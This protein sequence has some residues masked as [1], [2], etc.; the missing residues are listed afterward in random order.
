VA[1][2]I[3]ACLARLPTPD[4]IHILVTTRGLPYRV[5]LDAGYVVGFE[6]LL[7][8]HRA[9]ANADASALAGSPQTDQGG[10]FSASV[11]NPSHVGALPSTDRCDFTESNDYAQWYSAAC[12]LLR[13]G[14]YPAPFDRH[15]D[16]DHRVWALS[17]NLFI[18]TRL[19]GFDANDAM[20]LV[21]RAIAADGTFPSSP[22]LCMRG[23]DSARGARDPECEMVVR[24]LAA[25]GLPAAWVDTFD[26]DLSGEV[27]SGYLTG[28]ASM[29]G[30]IAG[31][32]YEPGAVVDNLT[33]YGA[34]PQNFFCDASG[35]QCP[36]SESQTSVARFIRA[37]ATGA[38]GT[39][40]E[41]LNNV[42]PNASLYLLYSAGYS[43]GE[44]YLFSQRYL[45]WQNLTLGDPLTTPHAMRP[46]VLDGETTVAEG[47]TWI[48]T[49]EHA[50]GITWTRAYVDDQL[51]AEASGPELPVPVDLLGIEGDTV[52]VYVVA[53]AAA[54]SLDRT[55]WPVDPITPTPGVRGWR[56]LSVSIGP[57]E[58][59]PDEDTGVFEEHDT[60][61]PT[62]PR[63]DTSPADSGSPGS[64]DAARPKSESGGC[65]TLSHHGRGLSG[66]VL[67]LALGWRRRR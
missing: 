24:Y 6:A 35:E 43:L 42:F 65:T 12:Q 54:T 29:T 28:A 15:A 11:I 52:D 59:S 5:D 62:E 47:G 60:S 49:V 8:I 66:L 44:S 48:A 46:T 26:P 22:L 16:W 9:T 39:V 21:D 27:V 2:A 4:D 17:G 10:Y 25:A 55:G 40:A 64:A 3:E 63:D 19:D 1:P 7:Q 23:A 32:T 36:E 38:H 45:Y 30:A 20:D 14:S 13:S 31:N 61:E 34:V 50:H 41:P 58:S 51:V 37:G 57:P 67:L 56:W 18:V 33:S 53:E